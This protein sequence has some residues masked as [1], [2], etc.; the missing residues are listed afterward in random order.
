MV[1]VV[2]ARKIPVSADPGQFTASVIVPCKNEE[3]NIEEAVKR[4]PELGR[5]TE[6]IFC[7]DKSEDGTVEAIKGA[8]KK[9]PE[10]TIRL[11]TRPGV[12]KS[13]NV[14]T[15]FDAA[16]GDILMILD[17]DLT[18]MPEQL[19]DFLDA[20]VSGRGRFINGTRLVYP[21]QD[22]AMRVLN[23]FGN[24]FFSRIFTFILGQRITDTLCGTKVFWREDWPSIKGMVDTWGVS[25]RW[26]DF[27][28]LF[29]A[30]K[31]HL[32][33][34][35]LPVH[36][37]RRVEGQTKMTN[38]LKNAAIMGKMCIAAFNKFR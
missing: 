22:Q 32:K 20:L 7:D 9:Y 25:D 28:L 11:V 24:I 27:D 37:Q 36:Y 1:E 16:T 35:E 3:G 34:I 6:I 21:M 8:Q 19:P 5:G 38:R 10:K 12:C 31:L 18:V 13:K 14:W 30:A 15:G 2:V 26:G 4:I 17:A 23:I 29:G 33:I